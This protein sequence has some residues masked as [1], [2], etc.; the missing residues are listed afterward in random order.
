MFL[1]F[2]MLVYFYSD[3]NYV[4]T[5]FQ[6]TYTVTEC[7]YNCSGHGSCNPATHQ[8]TCGSGYKGVGCEVEYCPDM[9][10]I[11]DSLG[12]CHTSQQHCECSQ[13]NTGYSCSLSLYDTEEGQSTWHSLSPENTGFS[14]RAGHAGCFIEQTNSMYIFG[15]NLTKNNFY[16]RMCRM[17]SKF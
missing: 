13:G 12:V 15:G 2:Q 7:P 1:S 5:G 11:V 8:C 10:G 14:G 4:L 3:R 9:C 6:A 17:H 16:Q